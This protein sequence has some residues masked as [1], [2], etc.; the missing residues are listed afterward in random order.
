MSRGFE[1]RGLPRGAAVRPTDPDLQLLFSSLYHHGGLSADP[2]SPRDGESWVR[3][4]LSPVELRV[5]VSGAPLVLATASGG[6]PTVEWDNVQNKPTTLAEY[7]LSAEVAALVADF[8]TQEEADALY[9]TLGAADAV[10]SSAA[11]SLA[12]HSAD[13]TGVHGIADTAALVLTGDARLSDARTPTT[14]AA[15]HAA[16]GSDPLALV[17]LGGNLPSSRISDFASVAA[18]L[19]WSGPATGASAAA[20]FRALVAADIPNLDAA[21]ITS[22]LLALAR[23]GTGVDGSSQAINRVFASPA[24]GAAGAA[25]F[26]ALVAGDIPSLD[27]SKIGSGTVPVS[28]GG[29]GIATLPQYAMLYAPAANT[30]ASLAPP[31]GVLGSYLR[32]T[33]GTAPAWSPVQ[34]LDVTG[35]ADLIPYFDSGGLAQGISYAGSIGQVLIGQDVG[36]GT[37]HTPPAWGYITASNLDPSLALPWANVDKSSSSL[38]DLAA[39]SATDLNTGNLAYARLPNA[40]GTWNAGGGT[41]T[42]TGKI[43]ASAGANVATGQTYQVNNTQVVKAR[44]TGWAVPTGTLQRS[45]YASYTAPTI[46]AAYTQSEVQAMANALQAVSRVLAAIVTDLHGTAGH[47]L[48]GT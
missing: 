31:G 12:V 23:G 29:T 37:S 42:L 44:I 30:L 3:I 14:H 45:T 24:S 18:N 25:A 17:N 7:G 35:P 2:P 38:A 5:Q 1:R 11:D 39:R 9:D 28:R 26:R 6:V 41:V 47:G 34:L 33:S 8:L 36:L 19:L 27:A 13:T 43:S 46:S 22:G 4:D 40:G 16:A 32:A 10:A 20:V 21:K 48:I 15:S